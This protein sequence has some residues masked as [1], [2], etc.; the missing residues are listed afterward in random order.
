MVRDQNSV[1]QIKNKIG[2]NEGEKVMGGMKE[3]G[4]ESSRS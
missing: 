4:G 2:K 1:V 3:G